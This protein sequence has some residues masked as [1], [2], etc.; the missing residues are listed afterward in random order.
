MD[1]QWCSTKKPYQRKHFTGSIKPRTKKKST[2][3]WIYK[4]RTKKHI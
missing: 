4:S 1:P 3:H 2:L